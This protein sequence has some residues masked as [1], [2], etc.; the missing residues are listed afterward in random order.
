MVGPP[1]GWGD[2]GRFLP[3]GCGGRHRPGR[4][5]QTLLSRWWWLACDG[6]AVLETTVG[7]GSAPAG[8]SPCGP[9]APAAPGPGAAAA[10]L[11]EWPALPSFPFPAS[12]AAEAARVAE[13][14]DALGLALTCVA[15]P[16]GLAAPVWPW[17][18]SVF[19]QAQ[20]LSVVEPSVAA[21]GHLDSCAGP[22]PTLSCASRPAP[23][24]AREPGQPRYLW[25]RRGSRDPS[26]G[27]PARPS[28]V[29]RFRLAA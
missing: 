16:L 12:V 22:G 3:G 13:T 8:G 4:P 5:A 17:P 29:R 14:A 20:L 21:D 19:P 1:S 26:L 9:C 24:G 27:F 10:S 18:A 25:L 7:L 28:E 11:E 23:G 15:P 6:G 2:V